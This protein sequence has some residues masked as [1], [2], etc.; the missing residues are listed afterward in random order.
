MHAVRKPAF[1]MS[2]GGVFWK[3]ELMRFSTFD[4]PQIHSGFVGECEVFSIR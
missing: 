3:R 2:K 1:D 4:L